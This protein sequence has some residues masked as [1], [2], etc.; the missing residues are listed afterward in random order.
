ML[1]SFSLEW[2]RMQSEWDALDVETRA[3]ASLGFE[4]VVDRE[5]DGEHKAFDL[6]DEIDQLRGEWAAMSP[7]RR[8]KV[9][10]RFT[11]DV[12]E[13]AQGWNRFHLLLWPAFETGASIL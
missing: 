7:K 9:W 12:D 1:N 2:D 13:G 11:H 6:V 8:A 3:V 10:E 4:D 5:Q